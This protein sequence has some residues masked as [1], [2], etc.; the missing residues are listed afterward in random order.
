MDRFDER[1]EQ[2]FETYKDGIVVPDPGAGFM[3]R[4]WEQIEARRAFA[5]RLKKVTQV[6]VA[7]SAFACL[8]MTGFSVVGNSS[9]AVQPH[10]TYVDVL[11]EAHPAENLAAL[12][13]LAHAEGSEAS[14]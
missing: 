8:L 10:A 11:A 6:F 9:Q 5:F 7:A 2:L 12:G 4:L 13:I 1:L 3:P 14:H